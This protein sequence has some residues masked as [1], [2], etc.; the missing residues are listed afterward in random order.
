VTVGVVKPAPG[1]APAPERPVIQPQPPPEKPRPPTPEELML[2]NSRSLR[3]IDARLAELVESA[4]G[5]TEALR[6]IVAAIEGSGA[7][8][9]LDAGK[10]PESPAQAPGAKA[11]PTCP[12][13]TDEP[14]VRKS[15]RLWC[16]QCRA[17]L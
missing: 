5:Q 7:P 1:V 14:P 9:W 16:R 13:H 6:R 4:N 15:G 2:S 8:A 11:A 17:F 10:G 12:K 3:S